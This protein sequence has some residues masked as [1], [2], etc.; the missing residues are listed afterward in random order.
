MYSFISWTTLLG[1]IL[2]LHL[3]TINLPCRFLGIAT[4]DGQWYPT[5]GGSLA[6]LAFRFTCHWSHL[7]P[8]GHLWM[9]QPWAWQKIMLLLEMAG[10]YHNFQITLKKSRLT[11]E[12]WRL[13]TN[14]RHFTEYSAGH[15]LVTSLQLVT[16][17]T[18]ADYNPLWIIKRA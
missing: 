3:G 13:A 12:R 18:R 17:S 2:N 8:L 6:T 10:Y 16:K 14:Q 7:C 9:P 5:V 4:E 1:N 15:Q 11:L